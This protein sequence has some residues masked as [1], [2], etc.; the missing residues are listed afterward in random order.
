[1][2]NYE[3]VWRTFIKGRKQYSCKSS[4]KRFLEGLKFTEGGE[5]P[6][7]VLQ[8]PPERVIHYM[9]EIV[10]PIDPFV[11]TNKDTTAGWQ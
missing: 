4:N 11:F 2:N 1:M 5:F 7:Q 10:H 3:S 6:E 8:S 9:P